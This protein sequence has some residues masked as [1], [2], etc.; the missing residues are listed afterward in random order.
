MQTK[1]ISIESLKQSQVIVQGLGC[2]MSQDLTKSPLIL[3]TQLNT[4]ILFDTIT[5]WP[6]VGIE[7]MELYMIMM[8]IHSLISYLGPAKSREK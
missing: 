2:I 4:L 5:G 7:G 8:R 1:H 3:W 6:V